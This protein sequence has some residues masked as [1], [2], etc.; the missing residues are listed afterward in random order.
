MRS[1]ILDSLKHSN[2]IKKLTDGELRALMVE[3][4]ALILETAKHNDIHLSSNLGIVE[5][6]SSI[7]KVFDIDKDKILYDTGHQ[8]YV[9]KILTGRAQEFP[10]IRREGS[11]TGFM[12]MNESEFDHYSPGHSGNI[13][14]IASGMYQAIAKNNRVGQ[15]RK[16]LN[17]QNIIAVVGDSAFAN[18]LNFEALNDIS[19][20]NEPIIIIL[21]D[22]GMS[23]S[24][25]VGYMSKV[26]SKIKNLRFFH[27]I[28][29]TLRL[30]FN[31]NRFYFF[32]YNTFNWIQWRLIG[33]NLFENLGYHYIGTINGHNL[34]EL[35]HS[36]IRARWF[37]KQGPVIVHVR[38]K[39][40]KGDTNAENDMI[41][42]YH[43]LSAKKIKSY[44]MHATD[45]LLALMQKHDNIRVI[46]PAMSSA[47]N[48]S[49]IQDA[50]PEAFVDVGI[51][52]EHAISKASGMNLVGFKPYVY[53]YSSFLQRSYDQLLHDV[54]RLHLNCT[55]LIDRADLSGGDGSSHHGIYDVGF[56]KTINDVVITTPRDINQL[57]QL[58][59]LSYT[60]NDSIFAIRYPKT[61]YLKITSSGN[62][63]MGEWEN[64]LDV[65]TD[66]VIISYGPYINLL[67]EYVGKP[68]KI[69]IVNA[70]FVTKYHQTLI[71][72]ICH[73]YK[74]IVIYERIYGEHG[75][76]LDFYKRV[77]EL[78]TNNK[79]IP[80]H[81]DKVIESGS[82][83]ALDKND[84]MHYSNVIDTLRNHKIIK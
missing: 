60:Y 51:S 61:D 16:Y 10:N 38:T 37:A 11:L 41:G 75:L 70:V 19:F 1:G 34:K 12:N 46:N 24:Q 69:N 13:L 18:G 65:E 44:G 25:P 48:C 53:I 57:H 20:N 17:K 3:I 56:L 84:H 82:N 29:R 76:L 67:L 36:L 35:E 50:F 71:D 62:I 83:E 49:I 40:G 72:D 59:E 30:L 31:Y 66:T 58:M 22:N 8:T 68:F 15:T 26:F 47:S 21:N 5:L 45:Y 80:M 42:E 63:K 27:F 7:L 77:N 39:K 54:S 81:Y 74:N 9:H 23:I 2:D 43:S 79:I 33:K 55:L 52:E 78:H 64:L 32:I 6:S 14:S 4:R 73:R 28:E